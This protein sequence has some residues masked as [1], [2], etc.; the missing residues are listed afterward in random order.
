MMAEE[1]AIQKSTHS[2]SHFSSGRLP[3][4]S[5]F[6]NTRLFIQ[7]ACFDRDEEVHRVLVEKIFPAQAT[8]VTV[9]EFIAE[10]RE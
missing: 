10:Q 6:S 4:T 1:N 8:V 9:E 2:G 7:D 5:G 3:E